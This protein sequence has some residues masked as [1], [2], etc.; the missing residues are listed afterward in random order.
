MCV[1]VCVCVD[2]GLMGPGR[3]HGVKKEVRSEVSD[4]QRV[5]KSNPLVGACLI[6]KMDSHQYSLEV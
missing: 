4:W 1:R 2:R 3:E 5:S 6:L